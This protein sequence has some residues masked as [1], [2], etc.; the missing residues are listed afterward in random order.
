[1][2]FFGQGVRTFRVKPEAG[3]RIFVA[4]LQPRHSYQV[5]IEGRKPYAATSG[6]SGI[7]ELAL[8]PGKEVSVRIR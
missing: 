6:P 8:P 1:V 7:L 5:E 3:R 2:V 4:A